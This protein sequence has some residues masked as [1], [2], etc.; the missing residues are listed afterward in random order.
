MPK[1]VINVKMA[2]MPTRKPESAQASPLS[3]FAAIKDEPGPAK[4]RRNAQR[5]RIFAEAV[6]LYE[7]N[8]G[9]HGGGLEKTTAEA[10]AERS[11]V[12][13]RTFFRY[14]QSKVDAIYVDLPSAMEDHVALTKQLLAEFPPA[15]AILGASV[16]QIT[17][18]LNDRDDSAR[19]LRSMTSRNFVERRAG[20]R[21]QWLH[22]LAETV[23]HALPHDASR[24]VAAR[25]IASAL[26]DVRESALETWA[27]SGGQADL[28]ELLEQSL[29]LWSGL[30]ANHMP[31]RIDARFDRRHE[32]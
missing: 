1:H 14:F 16:I 29:E 13:V 5:R 24:P 7:E 6:R 4:R 8:G 31:R 17:D 28:I 15:E 12:S 18:A 25:A 19:L 32:S 21:S 10:I 26:L 20:F 2:A 22:A 9:E 11:D 27:E 30:W 23:V 3:G